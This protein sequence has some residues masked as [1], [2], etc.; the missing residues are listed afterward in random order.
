MSGGVSDLS[1]IVS[2]RLCHDLVSPLGAIGNGIELI[3]MTGG[4][5]A[6]LALIADS[7]EN[8]LGKLRF[9]RV[10]FGPADPGARQRVEEAAAIS[11]AAFPG[12]FTV[13]W[14]PAGAIMPRPLAKLVYLALLCLEKSLPLGGAVAVELGPEGAA[15]R[16]DARRTAPPSELWAHV[17]A[18]APLAPVGADAVQFALLREAL[19]ATG[20]ALSAAF[21]GSGARLA[22]TVLAPQPA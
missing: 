13:E 10:A 21:D 6:E 22:I 8:A 15:L 4:G 7:L 19:V 20:G 12:R 11:G 17:T 3:Q 14:T 16:V 2:A 1:A 9:L 18:G 5:E